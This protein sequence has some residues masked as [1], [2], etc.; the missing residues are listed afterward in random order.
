MKKIIF[1]TLILFTN[2]I[3][4]DDLLKDVI[5]NGNISLL[6][7]LINPQQLMDLNLN[8]LHLLRNTIYARYNYIFYSNDLQEHFSQ[9]SW[10]KNIEKNVEKNLT[11]IDHRNI[12]LISDL[13]NNFPIFIPYT[14]KRIYDFGFMFGQENDYNIRKIIFLGWS[15]DGKILFW[16]D[17]LYIFDLKENKILPHGYENKSLYFWQKGQKEYIDEV[18][19]IA[20]TKY[21][22][23]P[24]V[25]NIHT[26]IKGYRIYSKNI[27]KNGSY[28]N[29][30][31]IGLRDNIDNNINI[32][33]VTINVDNVY[34]TKG[35][36]KPLE[37]NDIIY[38]CIQNPFDE[39]IIALIAIIP[40]FQGGNYD[41]NYIYYKEI[42]IDLNNM[43]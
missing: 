42:G 25:D 8:E 23:L 7:N 37:E 34:L 15:V 41:G 29:C 28:L 27:L 20:K 36:D 43:K 16:Q 22:I 14:D 24:I 18:V 40:Y 9:F 5:Y 1:L 12:K 11:N 33:L 10:Y 3:F 6:D 30:L 21:N 39:N 31:E 2:I 4:A 32:K 13:E 38:F 19:K 17:T 26:N 35:Y